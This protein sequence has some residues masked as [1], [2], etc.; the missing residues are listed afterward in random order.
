MPGGAAEAGEPVHF[1]GREGAARNGRIRPSELDALE[2]EGCI[3]LEDR[4]RWRGEFFRLLTENAFDLVAV[5][6]PDGRLDYLSAAVEFNLGY[7][8]EEL[9][10]EQVLDYIH[11][12]DRPAVAEMIAVGFATPG[13]TG[14]IRFRFRHRRGGWRTLEAFARNLL[15]HPLIRGAVVNVRDITEELEAQRALRESE[16]KF[17]SLVENSPDT[18][19]VLDRDLR[20]S[21]ISPVAEKLLGYRPEEL[22]GKSMMEIVAPEAILLASSWLSEVLGDPGTEQEGE[23]ALLRRD[24]TRRLAQLKASTGLQLPAEGSILV[25][26]HDVTE[27]RKAERRLRDM[28]AVF[29]EL[30]TDVIGN[31]ETIIRGAK[32]LTGAS[33]AAYCRLE[34]GRF[35]VLSTAPGAEGFRVTRE[36][37]DYAAHLLIA[38]NRSEPLVIE[39]VDSDPRARDDPLAREHGMSSFLGYPVR[40]GGRTM[41]CLCVY[42]REPHRYRPLEVEALGVFSRVLANEEERL[43][44]EQS[45]KN[46]VDVAAHELRHPVTLMKGYALT[47]RDYGER[48]KD[49]DRREYLEII[50]RGADRLDAL[51]KDLL[52]VSRI[53]RGRFVLKRRE[54][55]LEPLLERAVREISDKGAAHPLH[56][57]VRG[58]LPSKAVDGEKIVRVVVILLDNAVAHSPSHFPVEV[59]AEEVDG[60][61]RISVLDRGVGVPEDKRELIF[62]RFYQVEDAMHHPT[63]GMGLG[64]YIAREIVE[65]H[66]G[67]IWHEHRRGGGSTFRF[68][69]P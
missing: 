53:E 8:P 52:D 60:E 41:G 25:N 59:Q 33:L 15:D 31:M 40:I 18:I 42:H 65:A 58:T 23:F 19:L 5:L 56:L 69:I 50:N 30:G 45:L 62:E 24:G 2:R 4:S 35:S 57:E 37:S 66:G 9:V 6:R 20:I 46:L 16:E 68:T 21:F 36:G 55:P 10:G 64:L 28:V 63:R 22:Q 26:I 32:G 44:H 11:E 3:R 54:Q 29:Q 13:F 7:L 38:G 48:L 27:L 43:A 1:E 17:R 12:E 61:V 34:G 47:L 49:A 39:D 51:I 67:R 14:T